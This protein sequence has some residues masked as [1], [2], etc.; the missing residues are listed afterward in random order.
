[1]RKHDVVRICAETLAGRF[2]V[3]LISP[4][5]ISDFTCPSAQVDGA[6]TIRDV[7]VWTSARSGT[8]QGKL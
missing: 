2:G 4:S 8:E 3:Q 6:A 7:A 5:R 1:M